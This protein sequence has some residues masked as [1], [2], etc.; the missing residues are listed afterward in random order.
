MRLLLVLG[1]IEEGAH[2]CMEAKRI[3]QRTQKG[4]VEQGKTQATN[5]YPIVY[6]KKRGVFL[7]PEDSCWLKSLLVYLFILASEQML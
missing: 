7:Y 5:S 2:L 1:T 3:E 4:G 6:G